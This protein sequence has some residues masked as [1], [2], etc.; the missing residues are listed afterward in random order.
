MIAAEGVRIKEA[1]IPSALSQTTIEYWPSRHAGRCRSESE[2]ARGGEDGA[3]L[4]G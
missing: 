1:K 4:Y 2:T 3:W